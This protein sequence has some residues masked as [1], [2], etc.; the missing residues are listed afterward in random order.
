MSELNASIE[1]RVL[2]FMHRCCARLILLISEAWS[3][4]AS[5]ARTIESNM[6]PTPKRLG[7]TL[8]VILLNTDT[9]I[10]GSLRRLDYIAFHSDTRLIRYIKTTINFQSNI[11]TMNIECRSLIKTQ[12]HFS[13]ALNNSN[14][15]SI[16]R[17][18]NAINLERWIE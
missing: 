11:R 9:E 1:L 17:T 2:F 6:H 18:K 5:N 15:N 12:R 4:R 13:I 7:D 10:Q 14:N 16:K 3:T 8:S